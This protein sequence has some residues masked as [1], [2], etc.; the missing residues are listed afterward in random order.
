MYNTATATERFTV[1]GFIGGCIEGVLVGGGVI[2]YMY[3]IFVA[4]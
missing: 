1:L 2:G 3:L 4:A